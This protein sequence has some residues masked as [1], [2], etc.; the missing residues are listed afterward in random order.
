MSPGILSFLDDINDVVVSMVSTHPLISKSF[1]PNTNPWVAVPRATITIDIIVTLTSL[2]F[3]TMSLVIVPRA[4]TKTV[5][6]LCETYAIAFL[7]YLARSIYFV[8]LLARVYVNSII[9]RIDKIY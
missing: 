8:N 2:E 6:L 9:N 5:S 7:N 1:S 3:F 4:P